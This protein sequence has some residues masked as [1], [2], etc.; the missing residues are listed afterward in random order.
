MRSNFQNH[1]MPEQTAEIDLDI[2]LNAEELE[3]L[4]CGRIPMTMEDRWFLF[5][6]DGRFHCIRSWTGACIYIADVTEAGEI[7]H[8]VVNRDPK[9]YTCTD[10]EEDRWMLKYL[11]L[12]CAGRM[13]EAADALDEA[14]RIA[15]A[16]KGD[17]ENGGKA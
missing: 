7:L 14:V 9:Q 17:E 13:E 1:P 4:K 16:E 2:R 3:K 8:A 6:E 12:C 10:D 5:Y 11:V 15:K